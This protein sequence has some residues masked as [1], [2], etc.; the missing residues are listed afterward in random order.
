MLDSNLADLYE[1]SV[2]VLNQVVKRNIE[3]FPYDFMFQLNK[4]EF[5]FLRSQFVTANLK[6]S[7]KRFFPY[8]FTEQGVS[9]LAGILRSKQAVEVNILIVRAFVAMRRFIS[10]NASIFS[11][12]DDVERKQLTFQIKTSKNFEKVFDALEINVPKQGIF[13]DGQIFDAYNFVSDL[14]R[15]AKKSIILIDNYV[16]D[17]VLTLFSKRTKNVEVIIYTKNVSETL[18]LD[19][20]KFNSQYESIKVNKFDKSHDRFLIIDH[21]EVYHIGA[22]LKDLG[23]KWFAFSKLDI[24]SLDLIEKLRI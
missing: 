15:S 5:D 22:S 2:K 4:I 17:S 24:E 18:R 10:Q 3:R 20:E 13:F 16:D 6:W 21:D 1:V 14:I 7:K 19:L 8:V 23:R 12:I 9:M 11:R